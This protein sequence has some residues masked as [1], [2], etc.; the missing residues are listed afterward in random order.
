[1]RR[2]AKGH[3]EKRAIFGSAMAMGTILRGRESKIRQGSPDTAEML[4]SLER[5]V[6][7]LRR[8]VDGLG[9]GS[10]AAGA[11]RSS[12]SSDS[13]PGRAWGK[14]GAN[15]GGVNARGKVQ[16]RPI[17]ARHCRS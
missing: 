3:Y 4:E 6:E 8:R 12:A 7:E 16:G 17:A 1:M 13:R 14:S 5:E 15:G 11:A 2:D 10:A 9:S